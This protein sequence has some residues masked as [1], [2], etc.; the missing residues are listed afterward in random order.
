MKSKIII[1]IFVNICLLLIG[2][3][4]DEK[5]KTIVTDFGVNSETKN[6][7]SKLLFGNDTLYF[8]DSRGQLFQI[9]KDAKPF[10]YDIDNNF[11][12]FVSK[13][14]GK[15]YLYNHIDRNVRILNSPK[16]YYVREPK[17]YN[18]E[19]F[20]TVA[21]NKDIDPYPSWLYVTSIDDKGFVKQITDFSVNLSYVKLYKGLFVLPAYNNNVG[22]ILVNSNTK[23]YVKISEEFP[24]NFNYEINSDKLYFVNKDEQKIVIDLNHWVK[25]DY[26]VTPNTYTNNDNI[27]SFQENHD[28]L[29]S[30]SHI[31]YFRDN[32]GRLF[33]ITKDANASDYAVSRNIVVYVSQKDGKLY[34]YDFLDK[35]I[36]PLNLPEKYF[37]RK[38]KLYKNSVFYTVMNGVEDV[39]P[40]YLFVTDIQNGIVQEVIHSYIDIYSLL[41]YKNFYIFKDFGKAKLVLLNPDTY[42]Y[43]YMP[44]SGKSLY[45]CMIRA[46][47]LISVDN[48]GNETEIV[49][50]LDYWVNELEKL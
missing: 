31:L 41:E 39:N 14:N 35:K 36:K 1:F 10:N 15:L 25:Q 22:T 13:Y 7:N 48:A 43:I 42:K 40:A 19:I 11:V 3:L 49:N 32:K 38:P 6:T 33:E 16:K 47:K 29:Y 5:S 30:R 17:F 18:G 24:V 20:Y 26:S 23:Q 46:N 21:D 44:I 4:S 28:I 2:C 34:L 9:T 37:V 27:F 8:Q 45:N 12:A 50:N